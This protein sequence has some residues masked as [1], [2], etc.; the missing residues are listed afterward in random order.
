M[1]KQVESKASGSWSAATWGLQWR[2][3]CKSM[4]GDV[5]L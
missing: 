1:G 3:E 5:Y 2:Q 4:D